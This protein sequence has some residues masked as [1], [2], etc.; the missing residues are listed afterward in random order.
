MLDSANYR[1][2]I[3]LLTNGSFTRVVAVT[4]ETN[5]FFFQS[6]NGAGLVIKHNKG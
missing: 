1:S 3:H 5:F 6:L 2:E 4:S